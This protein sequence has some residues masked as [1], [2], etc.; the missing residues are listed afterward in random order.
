M[1]PNRYYFYKN[2]FLLTINI[3]FCNNLKTNPINNN[4][5][6]K[7]MKNLKIALLMI[8][9]VIFILPSCKK[10]ENDPF[11]SLKTRKARIT[12]EWTLKEGTK[13]ETDATGSTTYSFNGTTCTVTDQTGSATGAYTEKLAIEKDGTFK[14]EIIAT[15]YSNTKEGAWY[16]GRK[17]SELDI[18]NKET[19]FLAYTKE[20]TVSGT[21]TTVQTWTGTEGIDGPMVLKI[22]QL[23][24]KEIVVKIDGSYVSGTSVSTETGT[25]T[26]EQ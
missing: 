5:K 10:G 19:L 17:N 8:V 4:L 9:A 22:D 3:Y 24:N 16:F 12:G 21:T 13:T 1:L 15:G 2:C 20:T 11:L 14:Y 23:K 18:K 25:M 26:Y 7:K 6:S